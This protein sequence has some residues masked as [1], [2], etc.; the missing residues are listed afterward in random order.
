MRGELIDWRAVR[1][2]GLRDVMVRTY[3]MDYAVMIAESDGMA[4]YWGMI[5]GEWKCAG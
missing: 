5:L 1:R 3:Y 4:G 2:H